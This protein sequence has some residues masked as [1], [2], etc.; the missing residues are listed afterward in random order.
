MKQRIPTL[1]DQMILVF[2]HLY[3]NNFGVIASSRRHGSARLV[4]IMPHDFIP[5]LNSV[6]ECNVS[7]T[8]G[9]FVYN[10][11]QYELAVATLLNR[12]SI[13]DEFNVKYDEVVKNSNK[14]FSN[15]PFSKLKELSK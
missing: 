14:Q 11:K 7:L 13:I 5:R 4:L 8:N 2:K 9:V 15:N 6:Y 3:D 10:G 12:S 1:T